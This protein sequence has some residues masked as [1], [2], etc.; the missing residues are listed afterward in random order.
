MGGTSFPVGSTSR[1]ASGMWPAGR[2][3][4]PSP[5]RGSAGPGMWVSTL[6]HRASTSKASIARFS[7][8]GSRA[9]RPRESRTPLVSKNGR[10]RADTQETRGTTTPVLIDTATGAVFGAR[11]ARACFQPAA[12]SGDGDSVLVREMKVDGASISISLKLWRVSTRKSVDLGELDDQQ[13]MML[14][15]SHHGRWVAMED[16]RGTVVLVDGAIRKGRA[17][18]ALHRAHALDGEH[19]HVQPG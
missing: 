1:R 5:A 17:T 3:R 18:N 19:A 12:L 8:T 16:T 4:G 14:A 15:V 10:I 2:K 11:R 7:T 6:T 13:V 9:R